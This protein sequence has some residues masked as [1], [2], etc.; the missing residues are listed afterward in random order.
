[1]GSKWDIEKFTGS[2]DFG[3]WKVK[4]RA[5]L[6]QQKC[7]EA[8]KGEAQMPAHLTPVEKT[9]MNDKAVSAI[10]LCLGDKVLR[11]VSRETT[12]VSMWN[13]LDSLYM[14]KSLAHRQCLKQQLYFYR[15]VESKPIMEQLTEFNK[16][17]DDLANIDVNLEDEDK[18]LHLLCALPRSF[19][20]FKD[21]MLYG[22]EGTITLEEVQAAL[23]TKELTKFKELKVDDSG[24]GLNVSRGRSEN[25]GKGKGKN[26]RSKS[27]SK[28]GD[29]KTK[30]KCFIC[31][32]YGHFKKDC[33]E[34]KGNGSG[35]PSVQIAS[36]EEG[37][38]SAGALTVTSWEPEKGWVLDSG[39]SYHICPRK[40]YFE[41]L[42]LK[43]GGVVRLGNN[44]A[45]KIQGMGTIRLKMFDDR[46][47]LLKDVR[48][49]PELKRNLISIS[50]FDGLGYCTRI[51][52]GM[53]RIS[54]GALVIAKGSK[55][56]GLY[57]L[58]GSTVI[59]HASVASVDTLDITKL[60]HLR[61]GHVSERGLV[62]LAKQGLLG[63]EKLNKLD[64]C[65]NCTLGKQHKVKFGVGVHKSSRPFEYVHSDLW[66]PASVKTHGGGSYFMSIIDDFSRR[67]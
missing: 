29:N 21:T 67:V 66:G 52:R 33:P 49:I 2:N 44:K 3:L 22:K 5:I 64:F 15:M 13:K 26:S 65:D 17:I 12:A 36:E 23:R 11:E 20:N 4:M 8:L 34:R 38:E 31:H 45:C 10:I 59:G 25:R 37:Y 61:L 7:V 62:E 28:G 50:M 32:N 60:W 43:E 40:E 63:N 48:Y 9:E 18:A 35:N 27:R 53:M 55:I 46:D 56:H 57:I 54:H 6:I 19:E 42:E 1:M 14:T 30:Y 47:F 58:D 41:T 24:E 51:E 16:I 39:C